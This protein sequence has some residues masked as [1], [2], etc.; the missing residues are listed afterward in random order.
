MSIQS[1]TLQNYRS[2]VESTTIELRPLTL[3]FGYNNTG[4]SVLL[5]A[6]PL[7]ADSLRGQS[8]TPIALDSLAVR[9]SHFSELL[10]YL[11]GSPE[12]DIELSLDNPKLHRFKWTIRDIQLQKQVKFQTH[13][14]SHFAALTTAGTPMMEAEWVNSEWAE[15]SLIHKYDVQLADKLLKEQA[16]AFK[17]FLPS[18]NWLTREKSLYNQLLPTIDK[19]K[20]VANHIQWLTSVR[21]TPLRYQPFKGAV[22][23]KLA[24]DGKGAEEVLVYDSITE[25][26]ILSQVSSWYEKHLKQRVVVQRGDPFRGDLFSI[27]FEPVKNSSY[28][29]NLVDVGEGLIQVLP[30]LVACGMASESS[31]K[32]L[33]IEEPESHL[34]PQ[35]HAALAA[36]FCELAR[37]PNPPK[38]LLE[39][40]SE[41]FLLR[42]QLEIAQRKLDPD[43]V[44]IYWV[45]Q[46]DDEH[47]V[48]EHVTLDEFARQQGE[49]PRKTV[50]CEDIEL[51]RQL[52]QARREYS[53]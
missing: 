50:F 21:H 28:P 47:S 38:V 17:G 52:V 19:L 10:S 1:F 26:S 53:K 37:L 6:L 2:F 35:L 16:L 42:V 29:V 48:A 30:I 49:W 12:L 15:K 25:K 45:H 20:N 5:R 13:V 33:A 34:H 40:H 51:S 31:L 9:E 32:M 4:K 44:N 41:N 18:G 39:T 14:I 23:E 27:R 46:R 22:P 36:H 8:T 43:L 11:S 24:P 3:L 7:I